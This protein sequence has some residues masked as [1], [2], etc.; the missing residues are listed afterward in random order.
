MYS[1]RII[2]YKYVDEYVEEVGV[3]WYVI[4]SQNVHEDAEESHEEPQLRR[5]R[6]EI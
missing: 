1:T 4:P 6:P 5:I 2:S 3:G